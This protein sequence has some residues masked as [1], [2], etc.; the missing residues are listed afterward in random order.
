[1]VDVLMLHR[2][3]PREAVLAGVRR[4]LELGCLEAEAVR[5]L[6]H[7]QAAA[8]VPAAKLDDLGDLARYEMPPPT[9]DAFDALL[10][11]AVS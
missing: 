11:R 7:H 3:A 10:A 5:H 9:L 6:I 8:V 4:A 1:M 2:A